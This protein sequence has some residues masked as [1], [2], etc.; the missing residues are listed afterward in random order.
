MKMEASSESQG[1]SSLAAASAE[2]KWK[3]VSAVKNWFLTRRKGA[4]S[5]L[6]SMLH[7]SKSDSAIF[8]RQFSTRVETDI[9]RERDDNDVLKSI[10]NSK[11]DKKVN[12]ERKTFST[13]LQKLDKNSEEKSKLK[14]KD[15]KKENERH[16]KEQSRDQSKTEY[17][18]QSKEQG[19]KP[20]CKRGFLLEDQTLEE[21]KGENERCFQF[22]RKENNEAAKAIRI[23]SLFAAKEHNAAILRSRECNSSKL[24]AKENDSKAEQ[25]NDKAT[26]QMIE[27]NQT[28]ANHNNDEMRVRQIVCFKDVSVHGV[29]LAANPNVTL[30]DLLPNTPEASND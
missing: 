19:K 2:M 13:K 6:H 11:K 10:E 7:V 4:H 14:G 27:L 18:D 20:K 15:A 8:S 24:K 22:S 23:A 5:K 26:N 21:N 25:V 1:Q 29:G 17:K 12:K 30:M 3:R 28:K 9:T 16:N